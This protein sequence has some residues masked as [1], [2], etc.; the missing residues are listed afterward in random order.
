MKILATAQNEKKKKYMQTTRKQLRAAFFLA[1]REMFLTVAKVL[2]AE[3][4]IS[5]NRKLEK[6]K[7]FKQSFYA[8]DS[9]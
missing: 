3:F 4:S 2:T 8:K 1:P 9:N 7:N 6:K 5:K